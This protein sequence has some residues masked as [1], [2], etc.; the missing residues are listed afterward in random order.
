M[1]RKKRTTANTIALQWV[2]GATGAAAMFRRSFV[3][4]VSVDG[5]FFDEDFFSYREDADLAWRAQVMGWKCLYTPAAVAWHV[6]RV[7]PERREQLPLVI[8]WHSREEP[9]SDARQER[10]RLALLE[11]VLA[12]GMARPHDSS[13][14]PCCATADCFRH[15]LSA[16]KA[17]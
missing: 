2:F 9:L 3:E 8:N 13:A 1:V 15:R 10:I 17:A 7:T 4:A 11:I 14:M 6:R 5:E 12:G 16:A